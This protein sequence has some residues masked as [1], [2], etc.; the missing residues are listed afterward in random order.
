MSLVRDTLEKLIP[1]ATKMTS[2][3]LHL[4]VALTA[5]YGEM[6]EREFQILRLMLQLQKKYIEP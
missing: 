1:V 5:E 6:Q 3:E 2:E 4:L